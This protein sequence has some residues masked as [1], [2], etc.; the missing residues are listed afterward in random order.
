LYAT[1]HQRDCARSKNQRGLR[2]LT[3]GPGQEAGNDDPAGSRQ[4]Q[5]E[6]DLQ[7]KENI[8][9]PNLKGK[10]DGQVASRRK[11]EKALGRDW[12]KPGTRTCWLWEE[13][14]CSRMW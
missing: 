1:D 13:G 9:K 7:A 11:G 3:P 12:Y 8:A 6:E 5:K 10:P 14:T 4:R 2:L